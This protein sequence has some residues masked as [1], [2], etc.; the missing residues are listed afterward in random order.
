M[1]EKI[2]T[3]NKEEYPNNAGFVNQCLLLLGQSFDGLADRCMVE[4]AFSGDLT[5]G[6]EPTVNALKK[7]KESYIKI[8]QEQ[9]KSFNKQ[10]LASMDELVKSSGAIDMLR[11]AIEVGKV[12]SLEELPSRKIEFKNNVK[13]IPWLEIIKEII[14]AILTLLEEF[15]TIPGWLKKI[16]TE[17]LKIIDKIFGGMPHEDLST[18]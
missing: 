1:A 14:N 6:I 7:A 15:L 8:C 4:E 18:Q 9:V 13:R 2:N 10:A 3:P 12:P 17:L 16:I 5:G 11:A